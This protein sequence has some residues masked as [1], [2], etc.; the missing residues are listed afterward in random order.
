MEIL[1]K[2]APLSALLTSLIGVVAL[3]FAYAQIKTHR[4]NEAKRQFVNFLDE[5]MKYPLLAEGRVDMSDVENT[6]RYRWFI[7]KLLMC[8]ESILEVFPEDEAW[9]NAV[10]ENVEPHVGFIKTHTDLS[11]YSLQMRSE[12][13]AMA[14]GNLRN[15]PRLKD[16]RS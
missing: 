12:I 11:C 9:I 7:F 5:C 16:L 2:F 10:M 13:E 4:Q 8:S 1:L 6:A 14:N 3:S 15:R